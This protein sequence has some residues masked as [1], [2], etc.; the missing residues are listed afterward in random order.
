MKNGTAKESIDDSSV[1]AKGEGD[2]RESVL[3]GT[4][5]Q[6]RMGSSVVGEVA[7]VMTET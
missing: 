6:D 2:M 4:S 5:T 7:F 3:S 1:R